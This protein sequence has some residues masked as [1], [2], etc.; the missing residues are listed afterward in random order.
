MST[1][2]RNI[3]WPTILLIA[4][5]AAAYVFC[6]AEARAVETQMLGYPNS[7]ITAHSHRPWLLGV[8]CALPFLASV[9]YSFSGTMDKYTV[10]QFLTSFAIC[11]GA[12]F[13]IMF[14]EDL[15]D[16][17][18]DFKESP[19]MA[20]LLTRHYL[21][22]LPSLIVFIL[23][24]SLMLSLL[25]CL[26]K[27]S[28][29]QEIVSMIQTGR[30]ITRIVSPLIAFGLLCALVCMIFNYHWAPFADSQERN[31]LQ[32]AKGFNITEAN[33][34]AYQNNNN[35]RQWFVGSF[36]Y[37]HSNGEP[38]KNVTI[39]EL[40][41][42]NTLI[43]RISTPSATWDPKTKK[44]NLESPTIYELSSKPIPT[45][46]K[47]KGSLITEWEETPYQIIKPGLKPPYLG[48]PGLNS[49]LSNHQ[50]NPLSARRSYLTHWHYR[51]AQPF[52]CFITILLAAP[53]GIVFTRRGISGGVAVAIFLC[54]GMIFASTVFPTLGESGHLSPF[55][56]A[57]ATNIIFTIIALYLFYRRITGQPI[58][59][60]LKSLLIK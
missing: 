56:A 12:L 21:T 41:T 25:W 9:L 50:D 6:S 58:Y 34:V 36:P 7:D 2:L 23:P 55:L 30:S 59:Q 8:L 32:E 38:L 3:L 26:G 5:A 44:W 40:D 13:I 54:A 1:S 27:M 17:L 10:R 45:A 42:N 22:K 47:L 24:Y 52:I 15:Q 33:D 19:N 43:R 28:R 4:G 14:L 16:N 37:Q 49:W 35:T 18:S 57:W 20:E 53:L 51:W 11:F 39:S 29:N 31:I 48:I 46:K 60:S